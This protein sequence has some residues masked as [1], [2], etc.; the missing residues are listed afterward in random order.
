MKTHLIFLL[1]LGLS[2]LSASEDANTI[3][4]KADEI[5]NPGESYKMIVSIDNEGSNSPNSLLEVSIKGPDLTFIET[6]KPKV[7]VG[8]KLLMNQ[9]TMWLYLKDLG[10]PMRVSASHKLTG[11]A[12]NGDIARM[13][14]AADYKATI[15]ASEGDEWQLLL[16]AARKGVTYD[17]VR[18]W[19]Q[20]SNYHPLRA[21]LLTVDGVILKKAVYGG[22]KEIAGKVRPT[23][24]LIH[25]AIRTNRKSTIRIV[26]MKVMNFP[27]SLFKKSNLR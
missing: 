2:P 20:K 27:S 4:K 14:W 8:Q 12:A 19:I 9:D 3:L 7:D 25:D 21:D 5:R 1:L 23:E 17:K 22:Y 10:Q 16:T 13:R 11:E 24:I 26:E 15:E 18:V 6:Q